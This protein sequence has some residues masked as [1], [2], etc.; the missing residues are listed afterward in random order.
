MYRTVL[1]LDRQYLKRNGKRFTL[2]PGM[3]VTA[4]IKLGERTVLE[5]LFSPIQKAVSEAGTER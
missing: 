3:H 5:Y 1:H 2:R 4:E